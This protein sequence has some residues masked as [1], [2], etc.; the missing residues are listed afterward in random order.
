L[1]HVHPDNVR[2][3]WNQVKPE[4]E[5]LLKRYPDEWIPE[6]LFAFLTHEPPKASLFS[7]EGGF[8]VVEIVTDKNSRKRFLNVWVMCARGAAKQR[9]GEL[10]AFLDKLARDTQCT[11]IQYRTARMGWARAMKGDF[12][13]KSIVLV[14][15]V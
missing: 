1:I 5:R 8:L 10:L 11:E 14:R 7:F 4:L 15:K 13:I 3:V 9:R 6:Q 2:L 12:E